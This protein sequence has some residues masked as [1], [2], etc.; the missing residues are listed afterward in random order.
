MKPYLYKR[1]IQKFNLSTYL[2]YFRR[3]VQLH[4][5]VRTW[6]EQIDVRM[7]NLCHKPLNQVSFASYPTG[8]EYIRSV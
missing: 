7:D 5:L 8:E 4:I 6:I 3:Y 1:N 2:N